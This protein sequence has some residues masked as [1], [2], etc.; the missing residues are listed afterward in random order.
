MMKKSFIKWVWMVS[1]VDVGTPPSACG[2]AA[3]TLVG[4][5]TA[6]SQTPNADGG[7]DL[8]EAQ[9]HRRNIDRIST[10]APRHGRDSGRISMNAGA[11]QVPPLI[12]RHAR[13][14]LEPADGEI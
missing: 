6:V 7:E 4:S 13:P 10:E 9:T 2:G 14:H 8:H 5:H 12:P 3:T 11:A 1:T